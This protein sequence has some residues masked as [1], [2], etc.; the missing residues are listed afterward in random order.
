VVMSGADTDSPFFALLGSAICAARAKYFPAWSPTFRGEKNCT[1]GF[2]TYFLL[3]SAVE[4]LYPRMEM[5]I[6]PRPTFH[7]PV[8]AIGYW[9]FAYPTAAS[10]TAAS[11]FGAA[12]SGC[13]GVATHANA[14]GAIQPPS[15]A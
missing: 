7:V 14:N 4:K 15:L 11:E 12:D 9:L 13:S 10:A 3:R 2:Q 6:V 5:E 1:H 8:P